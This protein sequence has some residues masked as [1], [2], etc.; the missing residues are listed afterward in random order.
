M[1]GHSK[2]ATIKRKKAANDARRGKLFTQLG[3]EITIAARSG[4]GDPD[5]NFALRIAIDRARAA[6]MPK[7]N[8]ERA[9]KRGTGELKGEELEEITYECYAPAGVALLVEVMTDNRN[10]TLAEVKHVLNR[11]GGSMAEP[12]SVMWQFEQKGYITLP[13]QAH[14][15]EDV[16]LVAAEAGAEDVI[17]GVDFIEVMTPR[18]AL[19]TV[20][21]ELEAAGVTVDEARLEWMPKSSLDLEPDQALRVMSVIEQLEDLDD[22]QTVYSNLNVTDELMKRY[23]QVQ[24]A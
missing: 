10:R 8:I 4:G 3:R 15:Y 7:D 5:A 23:E 16:F 12:G 6:N 21:E 11:Q 13:A 14:S 2:W 9:I 17:D 22:T 1:S 19:Q 24:A 18:E 20:E